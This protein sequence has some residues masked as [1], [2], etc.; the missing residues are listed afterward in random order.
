MG[1]FGK[2]LWITIAV[3]VPFILWAFATAQSRGQSPTVPAVQTF[4]LIV[5]G[6][7][8]WREGGRISEAVTR[9]WDKIDPTRVWDRQDRPVTEMSTPAATVDNV[10]GDSSI[11]PHCGR[12]LLKSAL[13]C[14]HC[15]RRQ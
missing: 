2:E 6:I 8:I 14:R 7:L 15:G 5:G 3:A 4:I 9:V 10:V 12:R 11:C 1:A 13:F